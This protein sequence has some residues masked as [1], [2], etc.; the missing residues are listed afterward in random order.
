[1]S[2]LRSAFGLAP[3][4][5]PAEPPIRAELFSLERLEE[6]AKSLAK[7]QRIDPKLKM[8]RSLA[9][10]LHDNTRVLTE[11]YRA[12]VR[13][14]HAHQP[15]TPAAEWLLD[16]FH[17]VDEQIREITNDLPPGFLQAPPEAG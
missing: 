6:H 4:S 17:V 7:A 3:A 11:T 12:I 14:N 2:R 5:Q 8:G 10:R 16:N 9:P 13:A 15:I 1:M